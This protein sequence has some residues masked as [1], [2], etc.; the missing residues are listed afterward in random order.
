MKPINFVSRNL[1]NPLCVFCLCFSLGLQAQETLEAILQRVPTAP[2]GVPV[3]P[4]P[5]GPLHY[6]TAEGM[7][8]EVRIL[9][10]GLNH[11]WGLA[12]L[13]DGSLLVSERDKG[14]LRVIRDGVLDPEPVAG[15]PEIRG[16][17]WTGL[18]DVMLHPKFKDNQLIYLTYNK[19]LSKDSAAIA[20]MRGTWDGKALRNAEDIFITD[21]GVAGSSPLLFDNEGMLYV[22]FYGGSEDA[23]DLTQLRGKVLRLTDNGK[24]PPDSPFIKKPGARP[25]IFT[26]GHRTT[27]R[28]VLHPETREIWNLEMGPNGGEEVNILKPGA[29]YGWPLVS[30]GRD[31]AGPWQ[32]KYFQKEGYEDPV[33]YWMPS[34][35]VS[36]MTFYT[37]DKLPLWKGDLLVGGLRMGEI[38]ATGHLQRI[39]FNANGEEIRREMLLTDLR[40]RIRGVHQGIDGF[41]YVLTDADDAAV[42]KIGPL[43]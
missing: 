8:I 29:N 10:R 9:T 21:P 25:E 14:Q 17:F 18:L 38:P 37:G 5:E 40:Q 24:V 15:L 23:Q 13:P 11:P 2:P 39:R 28:L 43:Q 6:A 4:L 16:G 1:L 31:Y 12:S 26:F 33:I 32:S 20:V 19:P 41:L 34:I 27:Q 30:L 22:S 3:P 7:D 35:S 42:L 36:S